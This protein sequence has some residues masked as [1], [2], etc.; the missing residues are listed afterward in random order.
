MKN[1]IE[2]DH[3]IWGGYSYETDITDNSFEKNRIGIAIEHGQDINIALN[4]FTN[5][6]T[7]IKLWSR[8]KQPGD[9]AYAKLRNTESRNYWIASNRFTANETA[10][11]IMG[12]DTV[13]LSGNTKLM[14]N[15]KLQLGNRIDNIDTSREDSFLDIDYQKDERLKSLCRSVAGDDGTAGQKKCVLLN[16]AL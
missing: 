12:T 16:G 4:S 5:D 9:W 7:G 13:I 10:F 11:D 8:E 15:K 2:C 3:G 1:I 6:R 14:V